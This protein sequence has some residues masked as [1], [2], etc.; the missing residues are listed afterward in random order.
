MV[1]YSSQEFLQNKAWKYPLSFYLDRE[2]I[3]VHPGASRV[4]VSRFLDVKKLHAIGV[5]YDQDVLLFKGMSLINK[6]Q[7]AELYPDLKIQSVKNRV[8]KIKTLIGYSALDKQFLQSTTILK[9]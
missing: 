5:V 8:M 1:W 9:Y 6:E 3:L 7:F 2:K 4:V